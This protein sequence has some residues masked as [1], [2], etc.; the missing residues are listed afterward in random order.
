M[1]LYQK[2]KSIKEKL[3]KV[4]Q[5]LSDPMVLS[6]QARYISLGKERR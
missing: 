6:D 4:E 1:E 3:E 5:Q 2:L